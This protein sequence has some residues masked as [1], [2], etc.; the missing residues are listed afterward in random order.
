MWIWWRVQFIIRAGWED[1]KIYLIQRT[2]GNFK[3]L[4][5][6]QTRHISSHIHNS[7]SVVSSRTSKTCDDD[8]DVDKVSSLICE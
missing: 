8:D 3:E 7:N 6:N 4:K 5:P 1:K 2:N